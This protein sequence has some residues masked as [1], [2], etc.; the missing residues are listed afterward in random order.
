MGLCYLCN[1]IRPPNIAENESW[2]LCVLA[3]GTVLFKCLQILPNF[4]DTTFQ[5]P[6]F[7]CMCVCFP[8]GKREDQGDHNL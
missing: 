2:S 3:M 1:Y 8:F 4:P 6:P 5:K 7:V